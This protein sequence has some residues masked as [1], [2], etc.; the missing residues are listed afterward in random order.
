M[1]QTLIQ[2]HRKLIFTTFSL[3]LALLALSGWWLYVIVQHTNFFSMAKWEGPFF[4]AL[5]FGLFFL[6]VR[7]IFRDYRKTLGLQ[8]FYASLSHELKT[9]LS[10]IRLQSEVIHQLI[11]EGKNVYPSNEINDLSQRLIEDAQKL[12]K[13]FDKVLQ[14][15]RIEL[16][17][18]LNLHPMD[19]LRF[20]Q[21]I[22]KKYSSQIQFRYHFSDKQNSEKNFSIMADEGAMKHIF[23]NLLENTI[24]HAKKSHTLPLPV[25][26]SIEQRGGSIILQYNDHPGPFEG[27]PKLLGNIFYKFNSK[28]GHGIGLYLI[29]KLMMQMNGRFTILFHPELSFTLTFVQDSP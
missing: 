3:F 13:E 1:T 22:E 6:L 4:F 7:M 25:D 26:L 20:L 8:T 5:L 16:D 17:G 9:P 29:K 18:Q 24:H 11:S 15:S 21:K 27:N 14:L 28:Q 12:E 2:T 10:S 19:L 23:Y